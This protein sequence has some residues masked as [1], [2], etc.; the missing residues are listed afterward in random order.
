M[1]VYNGAAWLDA[2]IQSVIEQTF[3]EFEFVIV[4]DGSKDET[5]AILAEWRLRDARIRVISQENRGHTNALNVAVR[6]AVGEY[7]AQQDADDISEPERFAVSANYLDREGDVAVVGGGGL[8]IDAKGTPV[9]RLPIV[10]GRRRIR[11]LL[12]RENVLY[13]GSTLARR[14]IVHRVGAFREAFRYSQ[15]YDLWLRIAERHELENLSDT[16][17]RWR[18]SPE[19]VYSR[20]RAA[21][22]GYAALARAFAW[23]RRRYGGDS[24]GAFATGDLA[25]VK[26]ACGYRLAGHL[27]AALGEYH[28]RSLGDVRRGLRYLLAAMRQGH[29]DPRLLVLLVVNVMWRR[30]KVHAPGRRG[31]EGKDP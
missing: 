1:T 17:F 2:S 25:V 14:S 23:E 6:Q 5:A 27:F 28:I 12:L 22:I 26:F 15:D 24:Y 4:D 13:H 10:N 9:G 11:G 31:G 16:L 20:L 19:G 8:V 30:W 3:K 21:Q 7:L 29:F 18:I